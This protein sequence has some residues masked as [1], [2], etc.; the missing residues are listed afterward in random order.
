MII[1]IIIYYR[2]FDL[3]AGYIKK[4][5]NIIEKINEKL[6]KINKINNIKIHI[7]SDDSFHALQSSGSKLNCDCLE[8]QVGLYRGLTVTVMI[9]MK[10]DKSWIGGS[11]EV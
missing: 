7:Y 1:Y 6:I 11:R 5:K 10:I 3:D 2:L 9:K 4:Y 8:N